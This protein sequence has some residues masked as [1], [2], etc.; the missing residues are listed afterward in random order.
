MRTHTPFQPSTNQKI[1]TIA[2]HEGEIINMKKLVRYKF[3][4][5]RTNFY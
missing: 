1:K 4:P 3:S 5:K 2:L